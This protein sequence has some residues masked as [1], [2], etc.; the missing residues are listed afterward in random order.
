MFTPPPSPQPARV[1]PPAS[2]SAGNRSPR[3]LRTLEVPDDLFLRSLSD[4]ANSASPERPTHIATDTPLSPKEDPYAYA[5]AHLHKKRVGRRTRWAVFIVPFVL[6]LVG[7]STRYI[8]H[9][10]VFDVFRPQSNRAPIHTDDWGLHK[11]HPDPADPSAALTTIE[12]STPTGTSLSLA[13][14]AASAAPTAVSASDTTVPAAPPAIPTPFPQPF[15]SS[16]STNFTTVA[17]Q[18]FFQNMTGTLAFRQC[19]PFSLLVSDSNEFISKADTVPPSKQSQRNASLL[20]TI[21]WGTCNTTPSAEQ[22][23]ANM[24]WFADNIKTQC[25]G[26]IAANTPIVQDA[27]AGL[28][29]YAVM[30]TAA[31]QTNALTNTYCYLEAAQSTHP[32]DLYLYQLPLG[33]R[34][35]NATV[36]SCTACVQGLMKTFVDASAGAGAQLSRLQKTYPAA[37]AVVNGACGA[38]FVATMAGTNGARG[39]GGRAAAA[40]AAVGGAAAAT[41]VLLGALLAL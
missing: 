36:P 13:P 11:R 39:R 29:A 37:A 24:G 38:E 15:D 27:V 25:A 6:A 16:L 1:Q 17:C 40:A 31:C 30:R 5:H 41:T 8:A 21:I 32:S 28:Q 9:P 34:L 33:L 14:S 4:R 35:P 12:A 22:C 26:D 20:N 7:L 18:T 2:A 10:A 23:T 3:S 19:R